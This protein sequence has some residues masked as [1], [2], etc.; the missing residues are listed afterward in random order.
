ML[1]ESIS[2]TFLLQIKVCDVVVHLEAV[3]LGSWL[4]ELKK[5]KLQKQ[6]PLKKGES[7]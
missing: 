5:K 1:D 4:K 6:V 2:Y 3:W 7:L